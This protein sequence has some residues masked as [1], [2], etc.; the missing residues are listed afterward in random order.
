[1][2]DTKTRKDVETWTAKACGRGRVLI[3]I[4]K[5]KYTMPAEEALDFATFV[6][7]AATKAIERRKL[8]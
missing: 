4:D 2:T 3:S 8:E 6:T 7:S 5:H 1:M